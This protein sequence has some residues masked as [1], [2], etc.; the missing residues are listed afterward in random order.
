MSDVD[1]VVVGAGIAGLRCALRLEQLGHSVTVLEAADGVGGRQRTDRIDGFL[2]DRGF[3]ILIP[4]YP[5]VRR[6]VDTEALRLQPFGEG[7]I[8]RREDRLAVLADP[9]RHPTWVRHTLASGYLDPVRLAALGRW[10]L[11]AMT[12]PK[13]LLTSPDTTLAQSM[14]E[15]G[16]TGALREEVFD[17]F[18]AG[19]VVESHGQT[20]AN[21]VRLLA[22]CFL[23]SRAS[24]PAEGMGALPAQLA[25]G[26]TQSPLLNTPVHDITEQGS[27]CQVHTD[28]AVLSARHVVVAAGPSAGPSL[29]HR[30]PPAMHGLITWYFEAPENP[31]P[32][33]LL[34]IDG[35]RRGGRV[36]GPVWNA[37]VVSNAAPTYAPTGRHLVQATTLLDRPDGQADEQHVRRHLS[38]IYGCPS[39]NWTVLRR[40]VVPE[41]LPALPPPFRPRSD[42]RIS[43]TV[44]AAGDHYDS[45]SIQGAL[46]S[47]QRAA[48]L[49]HA[50]LTFGGSSAAAVPDPSD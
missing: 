39:D 30:P 24:L 29:T 19:V 18:L 11:P 21:F 33:P 4:A 3:A 42:Q 9:T 27:G 44:T 45:S 43:D 35:R 20:S 10:L 26:L 25:G 41:A 50:T 28:D 32:F 7:V 31:H 38:E 49:A 34:A 48:N 40:V 17:T 22:R 2:I 23:L 1:V 8:V 46:V 37:A 13:R 36:P 6:W 14:D 12:N 16:F 5:A 15:A 47:G